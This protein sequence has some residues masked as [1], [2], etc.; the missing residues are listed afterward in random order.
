MQKAQRMVNKRL[1]KHRQNAFILIEFIFALILMGIALKMHLLFLGSMNLE[2]KNLSELQK[3][4]K[5]QE[6]LAKNIDV[7][8]RNSTIQTK[9]LRCEVQ[10]TENVNE[11]VY[12]NYEIKNCS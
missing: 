7:K 9:N 10:I 5:S 6:N 12:Q 2:I 4:S 11:I 1:T 8:A 3:I